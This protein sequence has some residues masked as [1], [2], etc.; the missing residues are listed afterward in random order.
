[1]RKPFATSVD[2]ELSDNFKTTCDEY[3][4]KMNVVIE[5]FMKQFADHEFKVEIGRSG[6]WLR[7]EE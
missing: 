2:T 4:L 3:G 5:A 6:I 7:L 1:M